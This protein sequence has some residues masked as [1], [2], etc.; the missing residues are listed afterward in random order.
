MQDANPFSRKVP[1]SN[2]TDRVVNFKRDQLFSYVVVLFMQ[3]SKFKTMES[4]IDR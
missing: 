2:E 4:L 3:Y 1:Y